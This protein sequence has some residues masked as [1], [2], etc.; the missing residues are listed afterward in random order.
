MTISGEVTGFDCIGNRDKITGIDISG[1]NALTV[2]SCFS[3]KLS[4]LDVSIDGSMEDLLARDPEWIVLLSDGASD[5]ETIATFRTFNGAEQ[6]QAMVK[7]QV[8]VIPFV[9]TDPPNVLSVAGASTLA[10]KLAK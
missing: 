3:N 8:V 4:S 5:E 6:L 1:N 2:L 7:E 10:E 9:L